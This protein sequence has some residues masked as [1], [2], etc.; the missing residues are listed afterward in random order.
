MFLLTRPSPTFEKESGAG[1]SGG[2]SPYKHIF[3][4]IDGTWQAAFRDV[5]QSNVHRMN[6]AL[7]Y[8][9][10]SFNPQI[11]MYLAGVGASNRSSRIMAGTVGEGLGSL[12]LNAYINLASNY[13]PGDKVYIFGFSRGAVAARALCGFISYCGLLDANSLSLIHPAWRHFVREKSDFNFAAH[14]AQAHNV[15]IEFLGIWDTVTG[16]YRFA[17]LRQKYRFESLRLNPNVKCGVHILSIDESRKAFSPLLWEGCG[18][19]QHME[20]IWIPGVHTD[21]GGGYQESFLSTFSLLLMIDRLAT[22]C[23]DLSFDTK[24]IDETLI[25]DIEKSDFVVN[26][27]WHQH[28]SRFFKFAT[29]NFRTVYD[30]PEHGHFVHPIVAQTLDRETRVRSRTQKYKPSYVVMD[31]GNGLRPAAPTFGADCTKRITD[32]LRLKFGN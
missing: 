17:E 5:F 26:D 3:I 28:P 11:Y 25:R 12:I 31:S 4:G 23:P 1:G 2:E 6:I 10:E 8:E 19:N 21:I 27:E 13:V 9:D 7:N 15:D 29:K 32:I 20:Q 18:D 16:P 14:R 24:Y 22:H 30:V